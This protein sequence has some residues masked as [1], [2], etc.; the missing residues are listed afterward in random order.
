MINK[1]TKLLKI[2]LVALIAFTSFRFS[3]STVSAEEN[4]DN[5][6]ADVI[7]ELGTFDEVFGEDNP[8]LRAQPS[9]GTR[10]AR[11]YFNSGNYVNITHLYVNGNTVFC[12]EPSVLF[13]SS[14]NCTADTVMWESLSETTRQEIWEIVYY[15]YNYSGHQTANYY[16]ATQLM[17]WQVVDRWYQ[18]YS[19]STGN[20]IDVSA[21]IAEI[22]RLRSQPQ[23]RP[24]FHNDTINMGLNTPIT[25]TDTRGTLQ[26]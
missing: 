1:Y 20:P 11:I 10:Y 12:L 3:I 7:T 9:I 16:I 2:L 15:G 8:R 18:P 19:I 22:N 4:Y 21:Q 26:N 17:I 6:S 14:A 13:N 24:S 25:L 5:E 23:G